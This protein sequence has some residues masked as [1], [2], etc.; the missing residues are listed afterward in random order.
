MRIACAHA[1]P[2]IHTHT[3]TLAYAQA[4][5][6]IYVVCV[7]VSAQVWICGMPHEYSEQQIREYWSYCGE[8]E[9]LDLLTFK[10]TGRWVY[11]GLAE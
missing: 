10:D 6:H 5:K 8:V 1:S 4:D 9:A 3:D 2:T 7:Y 11:E